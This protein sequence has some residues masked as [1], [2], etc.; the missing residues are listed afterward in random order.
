ML[1]TL[2]EKDCYLYSFLR[3][4]SATGRTLVFFNAITGVKR[5]VNKEI[6][7]KMFV[8]TSSTKGCNFEDLWIG[9]DDVA[10]IDAAETAIEKP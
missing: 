10:R 7:Q 9:R 5:M 1:V 8:L 3:H 2:E 4:Y 6:K